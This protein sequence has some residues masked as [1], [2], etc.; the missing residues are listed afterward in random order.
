[1]PAAIPNWSEAIVAAAAALLSYRYWHRSRQPVF[2]VLAV[3]TG[4]A[5]VA[6]LA[7][8]VGILHIPLVKSS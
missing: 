8:A 4:L 7:A 1:M 3:I 5:C 6:A 2:L